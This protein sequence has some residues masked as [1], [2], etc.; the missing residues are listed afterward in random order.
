MSTRREGPNGEILWEYY[1]LALKT[2]VDPREVEEFAQ[3]FGS[4]S[5]RDGGRGAWP[6]APRRAQGTFSETDGEARLHTDAQYHAAPESS[7]IL[8]CSKPAREGGVNILLTAT[9]A[10]EIALEALGGSGLA[11]LDDAR[12]SWTVPDVFRKR[13]TTDRSPPKPVFESNGAMRWRIDNII[14]QS[15]ED[16]D[17][18][19][20]FADALHSSKETTQLGLGPGDVLFCNNRCAL[21]GRTSFSDNRRLLYRV[22]LQ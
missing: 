2:P 7:F 4:V 19:H 12:W 15:S 6:I 9:A 20:A 22:R 10:R 3:Q 13:G 16:R 14:C 18:A 21:H 8:A 11:K 17:I 5:T 1:P